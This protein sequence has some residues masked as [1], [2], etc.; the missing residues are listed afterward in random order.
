MMSKRPHADLWVDGGDYD[1]WREDDE[2]EGSGRGKVA[3]NALRGWVTATREHDDEE[4]SCRNHGT[5]G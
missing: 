4:Q 2:G 5:G 3:R 1:R